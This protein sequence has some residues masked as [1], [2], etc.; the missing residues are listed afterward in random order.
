[1][2]PAAVA[3]MS[4]HW[5]ERAP[6]RA[7]SWER[8]NVVHD[9][10]GFPAALYEL[11]YP[12]PGAPRL[13]RRIVALLS[14]AGVPADSDSARPLDHGAWVPLRF[15]YP[16]ADVPVVELSL[17]FPRSPEG[18]G[19]IGKALAGLREEGVLL[20]GTGGLV[21]NLQR[22]RFAE[23]TAPADAWAREFEHWVMACLRNREMEKLCAYRREAPS[24]SLAAPTPEHFDPL[25]F[26]VGA[27]DERDRL[28]TLYEGFEYGNLSMRTIAFAPDGAHRTED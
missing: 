26:V 14:G 18:L 1:M 9:F 15:L 20:V 8:A 24:A 19:R 25:F 22:A 5:E 21:H 4:A 10:S 23:R 6:V 28:E 2:R 3:L 11:D 17:P 27:S 16:E 7:T 12:A 13:S